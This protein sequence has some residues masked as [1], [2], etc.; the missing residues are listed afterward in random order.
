MYSDKKWYWF[1][2]KFTNHNLILLQKY[3]YNYFYKYIFY[4]KDDS[5]KENISFGLETCNSN[6]NSNCDS[7]CNSNYTI[8]IL[9]TD[10]I[11]SDFSENEYGQFVF[12]D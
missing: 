6:Y 2:P 8:D 12:L 10:E 7:N 11:M 4:L 9:P 5:S 1:C 3:L